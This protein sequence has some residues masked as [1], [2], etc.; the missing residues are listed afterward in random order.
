MSKSIH[1]NRI[2]NRINSPYNELKHELHVIKFA[3]I[4]KLSFTFEIT[5]T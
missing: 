2:S 3:S 4:R 1:R 5:L